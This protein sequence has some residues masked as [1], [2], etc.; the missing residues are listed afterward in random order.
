MC[1]LYGMSAAP[2][3]VR[4]TFWLIEAPDSLRA[5]SRRDPDGTGIGYFEPDGTPR[6]DKRPIAAFEDRAFAREARHV[7]STTFVAHVR[8][9]TTGALTPQNTHPFEQHGR[10][11]AHNG[12]IEELPA[13]EAQLGSYRSLVGGDTDSERFFALVTKQIDEH[14]GDVAAGLTAAASWVA[15]TLPVFAL[16]VIITTPDELW[17]LRYPEMQGLYV[18]Q[19]P[20][21]KPR[22]EHQ[23]PAQTI[24]VRSEDLTDHAAVVIASEP[25]DEDPAWR[26]LASGELLHA[27]RALRVSSTVVIDHPPLHLLSLADL[28]PHAAAS[29]AAAVGQRPQR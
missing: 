11:F 22:L 3:R 16:N 27:D 25:M 24:H 9:A 4:A 12:V 8:D 15:Q 6:I 21:G 26:L 2:H 17:A 28:G 1:R 14:D 10:L 19:R 20:R 13:L 5:Q 23:S 7:E 18:L 29:Q